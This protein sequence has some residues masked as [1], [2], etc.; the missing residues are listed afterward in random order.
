[1]ST[2]TQLISIIDRY[3][4][5][6][7]LKME[8]LVQKESWSGGFL[9]SHYNPPTY[10]KRIAYSLKEATTLSKEGFSTP[11]DIGGIILNAIIIGED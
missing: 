5:T 1:M 10:D 9:W 7:G 2:R 4:K 8:K 11:E 6:H 3:L